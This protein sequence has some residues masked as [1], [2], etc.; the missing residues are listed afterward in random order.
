M[1]CDTIRGNVYD[2]NLRQTRR[3]TITERKREIVATV[4]TLA[5]K[6]ADGSV[7]AV[8]SKQGAIAF[9]GL[10]AADRNGVTDACAY[11]RLLVSGSPLAKAKLAQAEMLA[12]RSVDKQVIGQGTHSHD[13]GVSWHDSKG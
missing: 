12:G 7:K 6:L 5:K 1:P 9:A 8:V 13:G 2:E 4:D 10:N 11:R 3:Q